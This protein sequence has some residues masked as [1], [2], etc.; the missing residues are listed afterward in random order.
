ESGLAGLDPALERRSRYVRVAAYAGFAAIAIFFGTLWTASFLG[1]RELEAQP[2]LRAGDELK[3]LALLNDLRRARD[4][5]QSD[6]PLLRA[7]FYQGEK[8]GAQASRAYRN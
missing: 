6:S 7:G 3:L 4:E 5:I 2:P 1:K 8:L